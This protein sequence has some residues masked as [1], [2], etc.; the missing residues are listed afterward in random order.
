M[1]HF[2]PITHARKSAQALGDQAGRG[3]SL[4]TLLEP[5]PNQLAQLVGRQ[6]SAQP[7]AAVCAAFE[8]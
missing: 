5:L 2:Q 1:A 7:L 3:R 8:A 6:H 4:G